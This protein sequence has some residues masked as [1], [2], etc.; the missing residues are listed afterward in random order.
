MF[1]ACPVFFSAAGRCSARYFS[2]CPNIWKT[3]LFFA[4][5]VG[6]HPCPATDE[7][8]RMMMSEETVRRLAAAA[9]H[10]AVGCGGQPGLRSQV[11]WEYSSSL[12]KL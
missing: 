8:H 5:S 9:R 12:C 1:C 10:F 6:A 7:V 2:V 3:G 11:F 4:I